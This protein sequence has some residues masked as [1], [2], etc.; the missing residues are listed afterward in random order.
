MKLWTRGFDVDVTDLRKLSSVP[1][2]L[3][4]WVHTMM[5]M[6]QFCFL[7]RCTCSGAVIYLM[8]GGAARN[9]TLNVRIEQQQGTTC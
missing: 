9:R 1:R 8:K 6:V 7:I 2:Y 3:R 4:G 5:F